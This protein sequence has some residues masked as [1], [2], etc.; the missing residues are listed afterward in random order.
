VYI[1]TLYHHV[2]K[3]SNFRKY[4]FAQIR[5]I[6]SEFV[7]SSNLTTVGS[8]IRA[9]TA[10]FDDQFQIPFANVCRALNHRETFS[11]ALSLLL[12][13]K[14]FPLSR[15]LVRVLGDQA[16]RVPR[17]F[18]VLFLFAGQSPE[19]AQL[20]LRSSRW[21][22]SGSPEAF[23]LF[24]ILFRDPDM[25]TPL[26][27]SLQFPSFLTRMAN[28]GGDDLLTG[29]AVVLRRCH[30]KQQHLTALA[31]ATF[32]HCYYNAVKQTMDHGILLA[33]NSMLDQ[34]ARVGFVPEFALFTPLLTQML[35]M[36]NALTGSAA[37]VLVTLS[38]HPKIAESFKRTGLVGYFQALLNVPTFAEKAQVF[39]QNVIGT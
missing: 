20:V 27:N 39:L 32:F 17:V 1:Q 34:V 4:R 25:R 37:V 36:K 16:L 31:D 30:L 11:V 29:I 2:T 7:K 21:M 6:F 10:T 24:L 15:T 9:I 35:A 23:R 12:R 38:C 26:M 22:Q 33:A 18:E 13:L 14:Q 19:N 5:G 8:A 3:Y 28:A